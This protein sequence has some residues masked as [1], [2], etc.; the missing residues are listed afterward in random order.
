MKPRSV[1]LIGGGGHCRSC[2]DVI[3]STGHYTIAGIADVKENV[4][5]S[6]LGFPII[7]TD[8][9]LDSLR[10]KCDVFAVAV[11]QVKSPAT[12]IKIYNRLLQAGAELPTFIASSAWVSPFAKLG[13]GTMVFHG[14]VINASAVVGSNCIIN[15]QALVEHDAV[16]EDHCHI[17]TA[18]VLNGAVL[19]KQGSFIGSNATLMQGIVVGAYAIVGAG[20]L[21]SK[22]VGEQTMVAG[23][24]AKLIKPHE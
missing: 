14:A 15:N 5:K 18:A 10:K 6:V 4:G 11:G 21:V 22:N 19:V 8:D 12:R 13:M 20:S 3:L 24:P 9:D 1:I 2:I 7:D 23:V 16:V 17:S